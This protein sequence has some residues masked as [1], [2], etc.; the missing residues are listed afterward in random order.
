[1]FVGYRDGS[2]H[3]MTDREHT[4]GRC[5]ANHYTGVTLSAR[6]GTGH[7]EPVYA[8]SI[9]L[10]KLSGND[11]SGNMTVAG[12]CS[13]CTQA[14]KNSIDLTNKNQ[15]FIWAVGPPGHNPWTRALDGPLR[16]HDHYGYFQMDMTQAKG[17]ALPQLGAAT[18]HANAS[19]GKGGNVNDHD[20]GDA[21]HAFV[22]GLA[23]LI[24]FPLGVFSLRVL[25]SVKL[26]M[27]P[28]AGFAG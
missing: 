7:V 9:N 21:G 13:N 4:L 14:A 26:H 24:I 3:G 5:N 27:C 20:F 28:E 17:D 25:N 15:N 12:F 8:K 16:R 19:P 18:V 23:F 11:T 1:M 22:M 10:N 2:E 6:F